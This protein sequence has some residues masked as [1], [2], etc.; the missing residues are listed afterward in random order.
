VLAARYDLQLR[1]HQKHLAGELAEIR[2]ADLRFTE[3]QTSEHLATSGIA[4]SKANP[5]LLRPRTEA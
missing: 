4:M 5:A 1:V 2:A 3:R